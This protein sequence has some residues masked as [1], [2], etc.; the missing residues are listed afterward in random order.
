MLEIFRGDG[1]L[2]FCAQGIQPA[3]VI[4]LPMLGVA[5]QIIARHRRGTLRR[6]RAFGGGRFRPAGRQRREHTGKAPVHFLKRLEE[7]AGRRR[8]RREKIVKAAEQP[9]AKTAEARCV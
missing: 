4:Q 8:H 6:T 7:M 2:Q 9:P 3:F 5:D 1:L